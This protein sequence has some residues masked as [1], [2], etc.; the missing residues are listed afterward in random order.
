MSS[1]P[2]PLARAFAVSALLI[3]GTVL[4]IA[5]TDLVLPAI[6]SLPAALG[7][8]E[9]SA[10]LVIAA[11]VGGAAVGLV[12]FGELG[13]R[14]DAR[15]LVGVSL[16][17]FG[18]LSLIAARAGSIE[19]LIPL[20]FLQGASGAA[21]AVFAPGFLRQLF[22]ERRVVRMI[23]LFGSIESLV[24]GLAPL[25]GA[26]LYT[27]Y[28]WQASF[29]VLAA[30][31]IPNGLIVLALPSLLPRPPAAHH[32]ATY[33]TL[34]TDR[35]YL[36]Y[37][38][39]QALSLGGLL[40][41][42]FGSPTVIT[43]TMG[44]GLIHFV[45]CQAIGVGCYILGANLSGL[46]VGRIGAERLM[47]GGTA[48]SAGG[49]VAMVAYAGLGGNWPEWLPAFW[50]FVNFGFGLR[51]P[52]GFYL[53]LKAAHGNSARGAALIFLGFLM[54]S[55]IGTAVI[56]PVITGGL[57]PLSGGAALVSLAALALMLCLPKLDDSRT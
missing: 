13:A 8:S 26:W 7:G 20:R 54:S 40:V 18:L 57:L 42:V 9:A 39:S 5:G 23:G 33:W 52:I 46:I 48:M 28:G 55:S 56:A 14:F 6:P 47:L 17:A 35:T 15:R 25:A 4:G 43:A 27:N 45:L 29:I 22:D 38:G 2:V 41:F 19:A 32:E 53:A 10:Q 31:A 49:L 30:L 11:F 16:I 37:A 34:L 3:A 21:P 1:P 50:I 36:R 24:P 44:G 51:S 12:G